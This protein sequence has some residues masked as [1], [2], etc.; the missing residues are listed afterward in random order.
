MRGPEQ[1]SVTGDSQA[2]A[3]AVRDA[4]NQDLFSILFY[5]TG[6]SAFFVVRRFEDTTVED[7]AGHGQQAWAALREKFKGSSR[8]AIC[9]EHAKM[10]NMSMRSGQDLDEY[11]YIMDSCRDCLNPCDPP[12]DPKD[13]QHEDIILQALPPEY[14]AIRQAHLERGDFGLA[15]IRRMMAAI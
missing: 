3:R 1:P 8:E 4:A 5:S 15:N 6:G 9:A 13:R 12:E 2:T 7:G 14:K 10:N 11:L